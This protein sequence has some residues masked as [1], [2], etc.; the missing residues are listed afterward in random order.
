M[1]RF[2]RPTAPS[3]RSIIDFGA[4]GDR[5]ARVLTP[6]VYNLRIESARV[7]QK[8]ENT[9]IALDLVEVDKGGRGVGPESNV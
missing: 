6:E 2:T 7:I 1:N 8:N 3:T 9:S 4:A 5:V